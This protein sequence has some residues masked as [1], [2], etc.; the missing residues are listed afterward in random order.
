MA[1]WALVTQPETGRCCCAGE[2][3]QLPVRGLFYG[4]GHKPNSEILGGQV[5]LYDG[6]YV[7]VGWRGP[8]A[9]L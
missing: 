8:I 3:S 7:K 4:I 6:G 9:R 1:A 5:E 2:K